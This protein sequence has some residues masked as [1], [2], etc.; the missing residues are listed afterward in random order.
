M[1]Q[2]GVEPGGE[3]EGAPFLFPLLSNSINY[4]TP[5]NINPAKYSPELRLLKYLIRKTFLTCRLLGL[6]KYL[7]EESKQ[8]LET[9]M[10]AG[11]V[12]DS[13]EMELYFPGTHVE[14]F[15]CLTFLVKSGLS[16]SIILC[17]YLDIT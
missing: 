5:N 12:L 9:Q 15:Y 6:H 14:L 13:S 8:D 17:Q 10:N 16:V 3:G 7:L 2:K 4:L 1:Y 11:N